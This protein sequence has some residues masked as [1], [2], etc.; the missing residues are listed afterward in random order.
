MVTKEELLAKIKTWEGKNKYI[1]RKA[2]Q[3]LKELEE[4]EEP[5]EI[6]MDLNNDGK[7]DKEDASIAGKVLSKV[8]RKKKSKK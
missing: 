1:V 7:V 3:E 5:V 2:K 8:S 4:K 6:N